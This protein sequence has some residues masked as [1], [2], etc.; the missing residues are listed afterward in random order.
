MSSS[1]RLLALTGVVFAVLFAIA[2]I[3][4]GSTPGE[5]DSGQAVIDYYNSHQGKTLVGVFA[6]PALCALLLLFFSHLRDLARP[7][8]AGVGPT[9]MIAGAVVW[10]SGLILGSTLG[11]ALTSS[12][13]H[14]QKEV[15]QTLNVLNAADWIPF[16][17]G[18]AITLI[19]AGMT[20]LRTAFLPRWLGWVALIVGIISL[21]GPGGFLGFFVAPLWM[22]VVGVLL[23][24]EPAQ[25]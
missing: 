4:E 21:F 1:R 19:G 23:L 9:V 11:L 6:G 15:A 14:G 20:V 3:T 12:A 13:D 24:R 8:D 25:A 2:V 16:I 10:A 17:A 18:V 7:Q 5:K 22:L